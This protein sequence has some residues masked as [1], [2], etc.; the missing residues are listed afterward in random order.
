MVYNR[1]SVCFPSL[2]THYLYTNDPQ[3]QR[4]QEKAGTADGKSLD[5]LLDLAAVQAMAEH[6]KPHRLSIQASATG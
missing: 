3:I 5:V 1:V 6:R 2:S 4:C